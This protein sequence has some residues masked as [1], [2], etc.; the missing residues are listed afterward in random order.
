M[1]VIA[2]IGLALLA[3]AAPAWE[4]V[5]NLGRVKT[6][7]VDPAHARDKQ[8]LGEAVK[9]MLEKFG[10]EQALEIDFFDDKTLTPRALPFPQATRA[11]HKAK[12]NLNPANN[13]Q[14]FV[15]VVTDPNNPGG[16][17]Q[18]IEEELKLP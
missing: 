10:R 17:P 5:G 18:L 16:K 2:A 1:R 13:M 14:K 7:Y 12:F 15:W 8:V 3:A 6:I 9:A 4:L 11:H